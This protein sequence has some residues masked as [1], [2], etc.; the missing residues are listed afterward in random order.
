MLLFGT[1]VLV[2]KGCQTGNYISE[3]D[4]Q[5]SVNAYNNPIKTNTKKIYSMYSDEEIC[6]RYKMFAFKSEAARRGLDCG[7]EEKKI[8]TIMASKQIKDPS[9]D[10]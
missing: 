6:E 7:V 9:K 5:K 8:K 2:L 10:H 1:C 4:I 3:S